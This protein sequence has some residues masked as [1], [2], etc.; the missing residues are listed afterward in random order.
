MSHNRAVFLKIQKI[1]AITKL[2]RRIG[3]SAWIFSFLQGEISEL[4][5]EDGT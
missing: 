3:E 1:T 2:G 4:T 5:Q